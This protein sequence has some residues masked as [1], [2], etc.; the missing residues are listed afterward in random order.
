MSCWRW[1]T[2][3]RWRAWAG[4]GWGG[5]PTRPPGGCPPCWAARA[6]RRARPAGLLPLRGL[7]CRLGRGGRFR[8][9]LR[10]GQFLLYRRWRYLGDH[11]RRVVQH[12]DSG[13]DR[14]V[15]HVDGGVEIDQ[16]TEVDFD[17]F[18]Q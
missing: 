1:S 14:Q 13:G 4:G 6:P 17:G 18:G 3:T 12:L 16:E 11:L 7:G 9:R 15:R 2:T 8:R 5:T 10:R